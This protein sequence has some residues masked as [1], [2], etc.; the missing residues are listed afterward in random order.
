MDFGGLMDLHFGILD[1]FTGRYYTFV[2][3][4]ILEV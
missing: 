4:L 2:L 3:R 1:P